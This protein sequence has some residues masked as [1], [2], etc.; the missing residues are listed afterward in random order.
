M[1]KTG[2]NTGSISIKGALLS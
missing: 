2:S 1:S